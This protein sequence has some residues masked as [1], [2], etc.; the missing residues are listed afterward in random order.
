MSRIQH[1]FAELKAAGR[2]ALIPF[3]TAGDPHPDVT[4]PTMHALV[5]GGADLI[6]LGVPFSDPMADGPVIQYASE[7]ALKHHV[8]LHDVLAMV[9]QFREQ[10]SATPVILMGYL[11][12]VEIMGYEAFARE[13]AA[14]GVDGLL[15]V[16]MPPEEA[17]ELTA[18]LRA[19]A[20]DPIFLLAPTTDRVRVERICQ[21]ASGFVYYVSLK[22]ITGAGHLDTDEVAARLEVIRGATALPVGVGFGIKD[23]ESAARVAAVADAV[24]V[25]SAVVNR[26]AALQEEPGK[27]PQTLA[28]FMG[29]LR[30]AMDQRP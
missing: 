13:A 26:M 25:G 1:R 23:G 30:R 2:T 9:R 28:D 8:S 3:I 6:E 4:V 18:A 5:E 14:A 24:I 19:S 16:D 10:D 22:G 29:E 12:P 11:N 7:R 17:Q 27:I 21:L 15:T 20:L